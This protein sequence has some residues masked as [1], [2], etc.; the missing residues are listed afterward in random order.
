MLAGAG[1]DQRQPLA[2][3]LL[4]GHG[5]LG[6]LAHAVDLGGGHQLA[7]EQILGA[8]VVARGPL[9]RGHRVVHRGAGLLDLLAARARHEIS[10]LG[11][12][13]GRR[14]LRFL[15]LL[16]ARA[17]AQVAQLGLGGPQGGLRAAQ[18]RRRLL[19]VEPD[20]ELA[21]LD[22]LALAHGALD[23]APGDARADVDLDGLD[24]P[25]DREGWRLGR[26]V[27]RRPGG[28]E[29][30]DGDQGRRGGERPPAPR[31]QD[32]GRRMP[33]FFLSSPKYC[34][35]T[36]CRSAALTARILSRY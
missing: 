30:E 31:H 13:A 9:A 36:R 20:Q 24:G 16:R 23:D 8:L 27:A 32:F 12:R 35:A 1:L 34:L 22:R 5:D 11:L 28:R 3:R 15:D 21:A 19:G 29:A 6:G 25:G 26:E 2:G 4:L 18:L 10:E 33:T 14:R 7:R 17:G